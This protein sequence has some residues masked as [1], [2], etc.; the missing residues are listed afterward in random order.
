[1]DLGGYEAYKSNGIS[2]DNSEYSKNYA[3]Y[4]KTYCNGSI[5]YML[6]LHRHLRVNGKCFF[7]YLFKITYQH[8]EIIYSSYVKE[9]YGRGN[10]I[11]TSLKLVEIVVLGATALLAAFRYILKFLEYV[12]KLQP[13][14]AVG[15]I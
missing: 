10:G 6:R 12:G 15:A 3:G 4:S 8:P 9:Y 5:G 11:M 7:Y 1:M 2:Y 14:F 13:S